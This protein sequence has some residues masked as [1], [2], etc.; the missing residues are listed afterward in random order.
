MVHQ[1]RGETTC[2]TNQN[3]K[4]VVGTCIGYIQ[5]IAQCEGKSSCVVSINDSNMGGDPCPGAYP[6]IG[7]IALQ[8]N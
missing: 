2:S 1:M 6:K 5:N 3:C 8:C 7:A 4:E